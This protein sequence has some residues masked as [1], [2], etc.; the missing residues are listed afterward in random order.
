[1]NQITVHLDAWVRRLDLLPLGIN[2]NFLL[3]GGFYKNP[4]RPLADALRE[5]GVKYLR[6][7]G[8][9]KSDNCLWSVPPYEKPHMMLARYGEG[10]VRPE[11]RRFVEPDNRT[12]NPEALNF[13]EFIALCKEVGAEPVVVVPYDSMFL[14]PEKNSVMPTRKQ[15]L[16]NAVEWVNYANKIKNYKVRYWEIGNESYII[17]HRCGAKASDYAR[18]VSEFSR[19]MKK[20]DPSIQILANGPTGAYPNEKLISV[21]DQ[22]E[23]NDVEWWKEVLTASASAI[24]GI[25]Y[26]DYPCYGWQG[27]QYYAENNADL[28]RGVKGIRKSVDAYGAS[29]KGRLKLMLTETNSAD[30]SVEKPSG[31][32]PW[33]LKGNLGH[34][35]V[36]FDLLGR[37]MQCPDVEA[38]I[39]WNTRWVNND[40]TDSIE[41]WDAIGPDNELLPPGEMIK[42]WKEQILN[43]FLAVEYPDSC[44]CFATK[45]L[46]G[47]LRII[48]INKS[49]SSL[50]GEVLLDGGEADDRIG[51]HRIYGGTGSEDAVPKWREPVMVKIVQNRMRV[52][53]P[54]VSLNIFSFK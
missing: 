36:L 19:E 12:F 15:L 44:S 33:S 54:P 32:R 14:P 3:D 18:D 17:A 31:G 43:G 26:H 34:A 29:Q 16:E 30:W 37:N 23:G 4:A 48:I 51:S 27:Y 45:D 46:K 1:M 8:G 53:L 13:D 2:I 25:A 24:D 7:P 41:F 35:L 52:M 38:A 5:M 40:H 10:E 20:I 9:E 6:Y 39:V 49:K 22:K 11:F 50:S 42:C 28:L 21:L 47:D